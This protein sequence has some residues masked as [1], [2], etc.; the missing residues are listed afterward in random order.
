MHATCFIP[1]ILDLMILIIIGE[2]Y[3]LRSSTVRTRPLGLNVLLGDVLLSP[4]ISFLFKVIYK[5]PLSTHPTHLISRTVGLLSTC[6]KRY[7]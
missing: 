1:F 3:K 7:L 2:E 5:A 6:E 4:S